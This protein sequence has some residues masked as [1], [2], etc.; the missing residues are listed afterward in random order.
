MPLVQE[1]KGWGRLAA[2]C[3]RQSPRP[4]LLLMEPRPVAWTYVTSRVLVP[5]TVPGQG[6]PLHATKHHAPV[7]APKVCFPGSSGAGPVDRLGAAS[8]EGHKQEA[9]VAG[10]DRGPGGPSTS[11]AIHTNGVPVMEAVS[12]APA[13]PEQTAARARG[14]ESRKQM[15]GAH[16][17]EAP[18][19][20][21][22]LCCWSHGD[23][24]ACPQ[25][26]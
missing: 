17:A 12:P 15:S 19:T 8:A 20:W 21:R 6:Q 14:P 5:D 13:V 11:G 7:K 16:R 18:P 25:G 3:V 22:V 4:G 10:R 24:W 2:S 26:S 1:P 23:D 9:Q